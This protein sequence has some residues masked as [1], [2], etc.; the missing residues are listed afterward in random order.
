MV[1]EEQAR[2]W[3]LPFITKPLLW[4]PTYCLIH[5]TLSA[6]A[7]LWGQSPPLTAALE[8]SHLAPPLNASQQ[9]LHFNMHFGGDIQAITMSECQ[10]CERKYGI[11][12]LREAPW[13]SFKRLP[14]EW[15]KP[16]RTVSLLGNSKSTVW[17]LNIWSCIHSSLW[18]SLPNR[19]KKGLC[20]LQWACYD[21]SPFQ[22]TGGDNLHN[23][24]K[25]QADC[26]GNLGG[27]SH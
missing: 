24:P 4:W 2:Q 17:G 19:W 12:E 9:G 10:M 15:I 20:A 5:W 27:M 14:T 26:K 8:G 6:P 3:E 21:L 16:I 13:P 23:P 25:P 1:R 11:S 22:L 18:I 7:H